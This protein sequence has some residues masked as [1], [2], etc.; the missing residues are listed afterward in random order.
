MNQE[1]HNTIER[2]HDALNSH[3]I[4]AL[5]LLVHDDCVFETTDPPD[6]TR[7]VGRAAVLA[8]CRQFFDQS[9]QA[10]F[11]MEEIVTVEDRAMVRWR[12]EWADGHARRRCGAGARRAGHRNLCLCQGLGSSRRRRQRCF[13]PTVEPG[14]ATTD[15][16]AICARNTVDLECS[17]KR[18]TARDTR[19]DRTFCAAAY[20][21]MRV[22]MHCGDEYVTTGS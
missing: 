19:T 18:H 16:A 15:H 4:G 12:Y 1:T 14:S 7:H 11:E 6:G 22:V 10:R 2:F 21:Q 3:D 9:P 8:A 17:I 20:G 5:T 13:H